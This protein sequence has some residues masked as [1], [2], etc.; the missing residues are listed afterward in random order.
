MPIS[1]PPVSFPAGWAGGGAALLSAALLLSSAA[2]PAAAEKTAEG[3]TTYWDMMMQ[4]QAA[5]DL[6]RGSALMDERRYDEAEREFSKAVLRDPKDP[7]ARRMLGAAHYWT[8]Q[9]DQAEQEFNESLK[10]D[11]KSS[12]TWLLLG[13]V[14]AW[15]GETERAYGAFLEAEKIDPKRADIQ[16]DLGSIEDGRGAFDAALVRFRKAVVYDPQNPLYHYQLGTLYRK[17]GRDEEAVASLKSALRLYPLYQEAVLE[18]GALYDRMGRSGDAAD[19]FRRAV[20]LKPR[21]AVARYRAARSLMAGGK[22]AAVRDVLSAV[23]HLTPDERGGGLALS[24]SYGGKSDAPDAPKESPQGAEGPLDVLSRNL[25]RLPL[26]RDAALRVDMVF[27]PKAKLVTAGKREGRTALKRALERAGGA[28]PAGGQTSAVRREFTLK[29]ADAA[30]RAEEVRAIVSELRA[31]LAKAPPDA[32][33]RVGMNL[34]V[35]DKPA[36]GSPAAASAKGRVSYQPHDVGND[37]GLWVIGTGWMR[38]VEEAL[39]EPGDPEPPSALA[40]VT[41]GV[42]RATL[43]DAKGSE[44]CFRRAI[45][46]DPREALAHLGLGVSRVIRGDERGALAA[47]RKALELAPKNRTAAEALKWLERPSVL[48]KTP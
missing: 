7:L 12:Q 45:A 19:M 42:G 34:S 41:E 38:L 37:L 31:S 24:T 3:Q 14:Y 20:R 33:V 22:T 40:W 43:G 32:E 10:L 47:Y 2:L 8:G 48:E 39:P 9:V 27:L 16:M 26:D 25:S 15:R 46:L 23:F 29:A 28:A 36:A 35:S 6:S 5:R 1:S 18:L 30:G 4:A 21:D 44:E 11:P 13:I 17:L